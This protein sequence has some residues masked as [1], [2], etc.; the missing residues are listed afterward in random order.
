MISFSVSYSDAD[1]VRGDPRVFCRQDCHQG[2]SYGMPKGFRDNEDQVNDYP[3]CGHKPRY[4]DSYSVLPSGFFFNQGRCFYSDE[5][6]TRLG[7]HRFMDHETPVYNVNVAGASRRGYSEP[8]SR[9]RFQKFTRS[10]AR[11]VIP[12]SLSVAGTDKAVVDTDGDVHPTDIRPSMAID[13]FCRYVALDFVKV[14]IGGHYDENPATEMHVRLI[15]GGSNGYQMTYEGSRGSRWYVPYDSL[16]SVRNANLYI[17]EDFAQKEKYL[18]DQRKARLEVSEVNEDGERFVIQDG[19]RLVL[20][21]DGFVIKGIDPLAR[22]FTPNAFWAGAKDLVGEKDLPT[23]YFTADA[24]VVT[25]GDDHSVDENSISCVGG[26]STGLSAVTFSNVNAHA[27][28]ICGP[29]YDHI[30]VRKLD[31]IEDLETFLRNR[32]FLSKEASKTILRKS[33]FSKRTHWTH[34]DECFDLGPD[35]NFVCGPIRSYIENG[36]DLADAE[37][38]EEAL[39]GANS[40]QKKKLL[41]RARKFKLRFR[42][43]FIHAQGKSYSLFSLLILS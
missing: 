1:Y 23:D 9:K 28:S 17:K 2:H 39:D 4:D 24:G 7:G 19:T 26:G 25:V 34:F 31:L 13:Q 38:V 8:R 18:A 32:Q 6:A 21:Q 40:E 37:S 35:W 30:F 15:R 3:S 11:S 12:F 22:C 20:D 41:S 33:R 16:D 43:D 5:V 42:R 10:C 14:R 29:L 27:S 36:G